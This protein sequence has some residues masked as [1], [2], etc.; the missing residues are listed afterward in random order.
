MNVL[1]L[2]LALTLISCGLLDE[3][4]ESTKINITFANG[5]TALQLEQGTSSFV[6]PTAFTFTPIAVSISEDN[7]GGYMIWGNAGCGE[8][9]GEI[10]VDGKSYEFLSEHV[11]MTSETNQAINLMAGIETVNAELNSQSLPIPPG[12]YNFIDI[13]MCG[14]GEGDGLN[15]GNPRNSD[16]NNVNFQAGATIALNGDLIRSQLD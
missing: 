3:E 16:I 6:S 9:K 13:I 11:C 12:D 15:G 7:N 10:E 4:G 2:F 8:E 5:T 14:P 1:L